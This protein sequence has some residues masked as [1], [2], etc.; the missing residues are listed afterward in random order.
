M[1][2]AVRANQ[3]TTSWAKPASR[4][5]IP[6]DLAGMRVTEVPALAGG[7]VVAGAGL[8]TIVLTG[9]RDGHLFR[10]R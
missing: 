9:Q 7:I 5:A 4:A 2:Q 6:L 1:T 10:Q 3:V 8:D